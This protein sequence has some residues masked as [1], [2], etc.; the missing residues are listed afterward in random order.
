MRRESPYNMDTVDTGHPANNRLTV[1]FWQQQ[2]DLRL[3]IICI[4][5][6]VCVMWL[7]ELDGDGWSRSGVNHG[8]PI[9]IIP[10][11]VLCW[12]GPIHTI[13][14]HHCLSP[15]HSPLSTAGQMV[16]ARAVTVTAQAFYANENTV[17]VFWWRHMDQFA[18]FCEWRLIFATLGKTEDFTS[19]LMIEWTFGLN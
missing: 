18:T 19:T 2:G 16:A 4:L 12:L 9:V 1:L 11:I 5:D 14:S 3:D 15:L 8:D 13:H 10:A 17:L 6:N 7:W